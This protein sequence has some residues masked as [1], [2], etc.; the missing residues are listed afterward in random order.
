MNV[1]ALT[2]NKVTL[3]YNIFFF[4]S[5]PSAYSCKVEYPLW[6]CMTPHHTKTHYTR[7]FDTTTHHTK[8]M[9]NFSNL[10]K[11]NDDFSNFSKN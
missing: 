4:I 11:K 7:P 10:C 6:C 5:G 2:P 8:K 1:Y 9:I 3:I